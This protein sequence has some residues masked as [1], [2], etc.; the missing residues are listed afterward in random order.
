MSLFES[1]SVIYNARPVCEQ[2]AAGGVENFRAR[3]EK[4]LNAG[5]GSCAMLRRKS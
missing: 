1:N 5:A 3:G 2:P 4:E